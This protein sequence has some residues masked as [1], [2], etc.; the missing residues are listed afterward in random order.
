MSAA[1][2]DVPV[3]REFPPSVVVRRDE[4]LARH[5]A[6]RTGGTCD[7]FVVVHRRED[8]GEALA[9]IRESGLSLTLLGAGTRTVVRDGGLAGAVVRL[10]TDF[11][12]I[13][14]DGDVWEVGASVPVPAFVAAIGGRGGPCGSIGASVLLDDGW[15]VASVDYFSRGRERTGTLADVRKAKGIVT[16]VRLRAGVVAAGPGNSW[17]SAGKRTSIVDLLER[18]GLVGVRLR[19]VTLPDVAPEQPINLGRATARDLQLVHQC[20]LDRVRRE[21][22]IELA[23]RVSWVGRNR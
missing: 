23:P 15:D 19:D 16:R 10:G 20:A 22:G 1:L 11:S 7:A 21:T 9:A 14:R 8:L 4:L 12:A 3:V 2:L 6:W 5:V 17:F 18:S 13:T